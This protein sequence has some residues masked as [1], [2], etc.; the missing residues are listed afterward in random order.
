MKIASHLLLSL[1]LYRLVCMR[2]RKSLASQ[3][4]G[5]EMGDLDPEANPAQNIDPVI[6]LDLP[7]FLPTQ[8]TFQ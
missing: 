7:R 5:Q 3:I 2:G 6:W 8:I 1:S 4:A